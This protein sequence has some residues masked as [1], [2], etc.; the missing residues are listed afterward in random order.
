M[1]GRSTSPRRCRASSPPSGS[2][3]PPRTRR[4]GSGAWQP[5]RSNLRAVRPLGV[6]GNLAVDLVE[7]GPP[8]VGG[9]PYYCARALAALRRPAVVVA[10][11]GAAERDELMR[12]VV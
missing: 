9:G 10:K 11:A 2:P 8:R 12:P 7:G 1:R 4:G 3:P 6:I 5:V